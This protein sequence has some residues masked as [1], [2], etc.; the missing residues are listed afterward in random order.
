MARILVIDDERLV[1]DLLKAVLSYRGHDV[2]TASSG[3]QGVTLFRQRLPHFTL[4]DLRMPEMNGIEVLKQIRQINPEAAVMILTAW[5]SDDIESQARALGVTEFLNKG[6]SLETLVSAMTRALEGAGHA[7]L[8]G[9]SPPGAQ[10][11]PGAPES[12]PANE[13]TGTFWRESARRSILV[14][15]DEP[16]IRNLLEQFLTLRDYRVRTASDGAM[17]MD[18]VVQEHPDF[19]ILDMYMPRMTGVEVLRAL[20]TKNYQG[21]VLALT[22][23]QDEKLLQEVRD[24]GS[25]DIL[26]KPVDLERLA[27]AIQVGGAFHATGKALA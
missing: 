13:G 15:D 9:S 8:G 18:M 25:V 10:P 17:A 24:L 7:H 1:C 23:S 26:G 12:Q 22:A 5:G 2:L 11:H 4:L 14:V 6:L 16:L 19:I 3:R 27:L 20:R 21:R